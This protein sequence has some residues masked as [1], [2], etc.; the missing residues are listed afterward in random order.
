MPIVKVAALTG[1]VMIAFGGDSIICRMALKDT[2]IDAASFTSIRL[3]SGAAA[4]W[5]ITIFFHRDR[6]EK[7]QLAI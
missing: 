2:G 5:A 1:L 3:V 7:G 6:K 4:L